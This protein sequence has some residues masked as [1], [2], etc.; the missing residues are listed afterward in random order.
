MSHAYSSG[1]L[2]SWSTGLFGC[3]SDVPNCCLTIFCPC[4]T[5]G[6][7]AEIV[8]DG[9]T[10]CGR[11]CAVHALTGWLISCLYRSK[12]RKQYMLKRSPCDDCLV[13]LFC[14]RCALC[15]E[16]RELHIRGYDKQ[17]RGGT[18]AVPKPGGGMSR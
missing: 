16:Y 6:R 14:G 1:A 15:Q 9:N 8:D 7:I 4:I 11:A 2:S 17:N 13:H 3:F 18:M 5:F 10:S 12:M